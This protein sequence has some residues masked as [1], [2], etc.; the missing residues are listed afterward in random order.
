MSAQHDMTK[1]CPP[2]IKRKKSPFFCQPLKTLLGNNCQ[3]NMTLLGFIC[4]P[5]MTL[6]GNI[7]QPNMTLLCYKSQPDTGTTRIESLTWQ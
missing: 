7:Y 5:T 3:S 4:Q 2:N 6:L 1:K